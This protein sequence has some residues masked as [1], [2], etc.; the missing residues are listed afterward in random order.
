MKIAAIT[1]N[2]SSNCNYLFYISYDNLYSS[3]ANSDNK[4]QKIMQK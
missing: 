4:N 3:H 2:L 1:R